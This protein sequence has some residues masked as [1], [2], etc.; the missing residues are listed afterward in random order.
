MAGDIQKQ[1]VDG[2][3]FT[4][5]TYDQLTQA[6]VYGRVITEMAKKNKNIVVLT[7]DLT[8]SNKTGDFKQV[9]PERFFNFGIAEMN[10]IAASAGMAV[11]GKLPF[12]S[13]MAAFLSLRAAEAIRTDIAYPKLNVRLI[14]TH[15]GVSMGNGG[16]MPLRTSRYSA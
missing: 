11:S 10:M 9:F 14:A 16:T 4:T 6:E 13:T 5:D 12:A 2:F 15:A 1:I 8:R 3:T 7:S